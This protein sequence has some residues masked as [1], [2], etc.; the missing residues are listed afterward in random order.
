[1]SS[2]KK[3]KTVTETETGYWCY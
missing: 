2:K 1:M 3:T